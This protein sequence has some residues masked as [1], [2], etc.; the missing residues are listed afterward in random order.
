[1]S[2]RALNEKTHQKIT[3]WFNWWSWR[4]FCF[5]KRFGLR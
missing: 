3:N 1:M 4:R 2:G 5:W